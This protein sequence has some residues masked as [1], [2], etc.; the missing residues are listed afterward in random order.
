MQL[1]ISQE[2]IQHLFSYNKDTGILSWKI[3]TGTR[4]NKGDPATTITNKNG[5]CSVKIFKKR[6]SIHRLIWLYV[7]GYFPENEL[8]HINRIKTDNRIENLREVSRQC[9]MRNVGK[10]VNNI[11]NVVGVSFISKK[12]VWYAN[13]MINKKTYSLGY[14]NDYYEA[15]CHR[16]AAEQ[17]LNWHK[18][19]SNSTAYKCIKNYLSTGY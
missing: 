4:V 7:Y 9:N 10:R 18:C 6:Y 19:D 16:L 1:G 15:V 3:P 14:H 8:D 12:F 11:S 17:C 2:F 13:I 5:Y